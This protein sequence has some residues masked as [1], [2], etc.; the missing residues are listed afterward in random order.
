[1][2]RLLSKE[3][4][5]DFVLYSSQDLSLLRLAQLEF[6]AKY[7]DC[8]IEQ[9][10]QQELDIGEFL[11]A[12][13]TMSF[14][15]EKRIILLRIDDIAKINEQDFNELCSAI[16]TAEG[17]RVIVFL[18]YADRFSADAKQAKAIKKLF[19]T[20]G[21]N[22]HLESL[23][24]EGIK[25]FIRA[26]ADS[27]NCKIEPQAVDLLI[28]KFD[29]DIIL[30]E[31]EIEK[32]AAFGDYEIITLK[33]VETI[34]T[35][36]LSAD[37]F[38]LVNLLITGNSRECF[39]RLNILLEQGHEPI[40]ILAAISGSFFDIYAVGVGNTAGKKYSEVFKEL[41]Y[42]GSDYRLKKADETG[43]R[44]NGEKKSHIM[45]LLLEADIKLKSTSAERD[46]TLYRYLI[47]VS[48]II[49]AR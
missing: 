43:A 9:F 6:I 1:M 35:T 32:A 44:L 3:H 22:K 19:L 4:N 18:L 45:R 8:E 46:T 42:K 36:V 10:E 7:K 48:D 14:F 31:K 38:S 12:L 49:G 21:V 27:L 15:A 47:G 2:S 29:K 5:E 24:G 33:D 30:L 23:K 11:T 40:A 39:S 34:S 17:C 25:K 37:I 13:G 28:S 41:G 20:I 26:T 16:E